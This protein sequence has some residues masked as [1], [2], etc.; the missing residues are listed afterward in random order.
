MRSVSSS[1]EVK[2]II[3]NDTYRL[4][5][6]YDRDCD[7]RI[8][9]KGAVEFFKDSGCVHP[10]EEA[11]ILFNGDTNKEMTFDEIFQI[12]F[13]Q[14]HGKI[15]YL[16]QEILEFVEGHYNRGNRSV[17]FLELE[18]HF[19]KRP[20]V[21]PR[22]SALYYIL[23]INGNDDK[24]VVTLDQLREYARARN[25]RRMLKHNSPPKAQR[26]EV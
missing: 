24:F 4:L 7:Q 21:N 2:K 22:L 8:S 26:V 10:K 6:T 25:L 23:K 14:I 15:G 13:N 18:S 16:N 19:K 3:Q 1:N 20:Q 17:D 12:L 11:M 9:F 5:S